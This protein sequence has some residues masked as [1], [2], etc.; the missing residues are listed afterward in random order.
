MPD[1]LTQPSAAL[2]GLS[3]VEWTPRIASTA[4]PDEA[5]LTGGLQSQRIEL[6]FRDGKFVITIVGTAPESLLPTIQSMGNLVNLLPDWDSFGAQAVDPARFISALRLLPHIIRENI[7]VPSVVPTGQGGIQFE[8]HTR[9]I[10]LEIEVLSLQR[11]RVF[12]ED[13]NR[14]DHWE[15][16]AISN[17][18]LLE[19]FIGRLSLGR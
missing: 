17:P 7:P 12:F 4:L 14:K 6:N 18:S 10:D 13:L 5:T 8:W 3:D 1:S 19:K 16:E 2:E 9:G 11:Q 15:G